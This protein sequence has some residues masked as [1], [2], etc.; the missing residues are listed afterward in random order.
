MAED[1]DL[2]KTEPASP[3]RLEK[4]REEGDVPRSRELA[5][6]TMLLAAGAGLWFSGANV[7][8]QVSKVLRNSLSFDRMH[9]FDTDFLLA[10]L[11]G[12]V[13]DVM[14]AFAPMAILLILVALFTPML[15]GGWLFS[16]KALE[17]KFGRMNPLKGAKN[18]VSTQ[19]L[20]EL[21]KA[22]GKSLI[23]G[24]IAWLVLSSQAESMMGLAVTPVKTGSS[25]LA[26]IL[27][28][29]F[30]AVVAGLVLIAA[31]DM[32]Y[33]KWRYAEKLK[34]SREE[35]RREHKESDGNPE[36]KA[37]IRQQQ[38][39]IARRRMMS[40]IPNADVVVTNPTHYAVALKYAEGK[41][42]APRVVAKGAD[43]VA[44]KIR[45]IA[46]EN[47]VPLL[48]APMLARALYAHTELGDE[49]P[50]GLYTAVAQV[51]AYVFQLRTYRTEGGLQPQ[52]PETVEVPAELDPHHPA[53]HTA[54]A[55]R[56]SLKSAEVNA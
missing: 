10:T 25:V 54:K 42:G 23:V 55:R 12:K 30:F 52:A 47:T 34:M 3:R 50:E 44:A 53:F 33:Q 18:M 28:V 2:E 31:I 7:V 15:M 5:T 1:S 6:C 17:P 35:V 4:A 36:I 26:D 56:L 16:G 11:P 48:E 37:K 49:I 38:R 46:S 19:S 27:I 40:E 32:P 9:A 14:I 43:A 13:V 39:E 21:V 41:M 22:I 45:E 20:V 29:T 8:E 24:G 51:L